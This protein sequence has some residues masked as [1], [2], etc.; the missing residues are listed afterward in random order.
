M[1]HSRYKQDNWKI[2]EE[3]FRPENQRASESIFSIGNGKMGQRANFEETYSGNSLQ[4]HYVAGVYYPDKTRVGWW[5]IG[6]PEYFA[7]VINTP[8]W[9]G[10]NIKIN[11]EQI[12]LARMKIH[13]FRRI[14]DMKRGLLERHF[15]I[16]PFAGKHVQA[17]VVRFLSMS[18]DETGCIRYSLTPDFPCRL[19]VSPYLDADVKNEDAN[20]NEKFWDEVNRDFKDNHGVIVVKTKKLDFHVSTGITSSVLLDKKPVK[21]QEVPENRE[22]YIGIHY[23][24]DV[25]AGQ[26]IEIIKFGAVL[27]SLYH[28]KKALVQDT[29]KTLREA[30][31]SGFETL[32]AEQEAAWAEIWK[33][34]DFIIRGD[35]AA[36]QGIRFN[37]FQLQQTYTGRDERLNIGPKG[38]TGEKYGGSTYWDTE[39][40]VFP[41]YLYSGKPDIARNL[42]LYRY[43][44]LG[45]AI[46]N[47]R[48]LGFSGGAALYPMVTMNGEECHNEWE[49]TFE[50]IHR[51]GAIA[52][53]INKYLTYT[54]DEAYIADYGLEVLIALSRFWVQRVNFS[55]PKGKYVIL[56]VTGPNE[57]E[58]NVN[59]N[60]Y[61]NYIAAW[62]LRLT[63]D[64]L[65]KVKASY[66]EKWK[67]L[68][69]QINFSADEPAFWKK[70]S[71]NLFFPEDKDLGIFLQQEGYLDKKQ[72]LADDL[73][74]AVKPL[75][76]HWSWDRILRSCF[77][78]QADVL[79]GLYFF[80]DHFDKETLARNFDFY[81]SRTVH[82]SS[83]S[84]CI[85]SILAS[86][87]GS[88]DKAYQHYLRTSRL[89]L[90]D[91]NNEVSE[92]LHITSMAGTW[93]ALVEGFGGLKIRNRELYL[94]PQIPAQWKEYA[95]RILFHGNYLALQVNH[96]EISVENQGVDPVSFH[97][98][99]DVFQTR[100]GERINIPVKK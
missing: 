94:Y 60:W 50:E 100:P 53:A 96:N 58:N 19:S 33:E 11:G 26:K 70:V 85:H 56:G 82:E 43:K 17:S 32:L 80:E 89:D 69:A 79:Q 49:I 62:T 95:F 51:N 92:G 29:H 52:Y 63:Y 73:D 59:N 25:R 81:E 64:N 5:K 78:K 24:L 30:E 83:L 47:A 87:I 31:K 46:E 97:I 54:G 18:R 28:N 35:I 90:D 72:Q 1:H 3:D 6:Y 2:I 84:P 93:L 38:F 8:N 55:E 98:D 9:I 34:K 74:T 14:L 77:I 99:G 41:Y 40:F 57:Y 45:K 39:A 12:D 61:T 7:K 88:L 76:Q 4:G 66:P 22:K 15:T 20:Y 23:D 75:N 13:E 71:D 68:S 48:K 10:I 16:E 36:Q 21:S 65:I 42:L 67:E 86:R 37:I 91:Y 44:H 27:S